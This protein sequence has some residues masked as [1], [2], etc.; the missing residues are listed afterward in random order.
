MAYGKA[1]NIS[2]RFSNQVGQSGPGCMA[3]NGKTDTTY[4]PVKNN[5][6]SC[7]ITANTDYNPWWLVDLGLSYSVFNVTIYNRIGKEALRLS[8]IHI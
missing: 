2:S 1:A 7:V 6:G 5:G 4:R 3:V 8:L